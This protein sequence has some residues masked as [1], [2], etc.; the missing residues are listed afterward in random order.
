MTSSDA[1]NAPA[2]GRAFFADLSVRVKILA[3]VGVA[4]LVALIVGI[5]GL[6]ALG[7]AS[8]AAELIYR[9]N[10]VSVDD[11]GKVGKAVT[12]ARVDLANE[13]LSVDAASTT[14]FAKGFATDVET[15]NALLADYRENNP[16]G[17]PATVA[18]LQTTWTAYTDVVRRDM[19]PA[20]ARHDTVA[21]TRVRDTET[22][23]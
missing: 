14:K 11:M 10:L 21:W 16:A 12:Q 15:F 7:K 22:L 3:A 23:P 18:D 2:A 4:A 5:A 13:A 6:L 8:D 1:A 17:D 19:L 9:D 20:G